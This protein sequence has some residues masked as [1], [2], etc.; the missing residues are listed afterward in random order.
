MS[1]ISNEVTPRQA[2]E[3][4]GIGYLVIFVLAVFANFFVVNGLVMQG[5]SAA[6]VANI[7]GSI[8][9]FRAGLVAF[10]LVFIVDVAIAWALCVLFRAAGRDLSLLNDM[11]DDPG[12][13]RRS[14]AAR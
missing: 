10:L 4:A 14:G 3:A 7:S 1:S 2:S 12:G 11:N 6:T 8:G 5:D 9:L 13:G